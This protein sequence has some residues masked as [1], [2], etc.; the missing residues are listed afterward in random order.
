M[1]LL[2]DIDGI[3]KN[4]MEQLSGTF[5]FYKFIEKRPDLKV[6]LLS[7]ST[8]LTGEEVGLFF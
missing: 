2:V 4:G 5:T 7:N 8:I 3:L 1:V 6:I